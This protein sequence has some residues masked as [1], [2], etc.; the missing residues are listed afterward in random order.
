M[1]VRLTV[2]NPLAAFDKIFVINLKDR[3]DRRTEMNEQ[4]VQ[5]GLSL[6]HP[7]IRLFEA[8]RPTSLEGFPTLGTRG[9]FMSHLGILREA[10]ALGHRSILI[11]EDDV[12]FSR[13]FRSAAPRVLDELSQKNW[14]LFYG[15]FSFMSGK[16][17]SG[18]E[19][20]FRAVPDEAILT[21][22]FLAFRGKAI[23]E[24]AHYLEAIL[25]RPTGSPEGGPMH[26]D[27]AYNWFRNA[28]PHH[29]TWLAGSQLGYQRSSRTDIHDLRWFDNLPGVNRV[30][31]G[32]RKLTNRFRPRG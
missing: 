18:S 22:H 30:V 8:V 25:G 6:S 29:E 27:G 13:D 17:Y 19:V 10:A 11:L 16:T 4:L 24:A 5:I 28:H 14:S 3:A 32:L 21:S 7:G 9:C 23:G 2:S 26:V 31:A 20:L 15:G 1:T 12:N